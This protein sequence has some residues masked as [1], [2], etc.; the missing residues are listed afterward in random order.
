M[1]LLCR[2]QLTPR[3]KNTSLRSKTVGVNS[4]NKIKT[5]AFDVKFSSKITL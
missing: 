1:I 3:M 4:F 2:T 5:S